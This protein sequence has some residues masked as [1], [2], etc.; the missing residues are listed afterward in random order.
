MLKA[1]FKDLFNRFIKKNIFVKTLIILFILL[2]LFICFICFYK[3]DYIID[4]PGPLSEASNVIQIDTTNNRGHILTVAVSEYERVPLIKYWLAKGDKR[5]AVEK[6]PDDYDSK[7]EYY[8]SYYARRVSLY[9]AIIYA[10][11]KAKEVNPEVNIVYTYKGALVAYVMKEAKMTIEADDVITAIEGN[12]FNNYD[13]FINIYRDIVDTKK[14]GDV[15][16]FDVV[17]IVNNEEI[18]LSRYATLMEDSETGKLYLGFSV[19]DYTVPDSENSTPKF[20]ISSGAY[21]TT[22]NSGGAMLA[23]SIYNALVNEDI[24]SKNGSDMIIAGTGTISIDGKVGA[25]GGIEQKVVKAYISQVDVFFVDAVDYDDAIEACKKL[26]YDS[27]FIKKVETFDDIL[28]ELARMRG[29][30]NE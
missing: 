18:M 20:T 23:L 7:G 6:I 17:R 28:T 11:T 15:I 27:S 2:E 5:L 9:N 22:G 4:T 14:A 3:V 24:T 12:K 30:G 8:Y 16:N 29:E 21:N 13:E 1:Y 26:G 10:Y 25:I 19:F